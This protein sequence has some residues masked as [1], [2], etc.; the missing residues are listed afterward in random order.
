MSEMG[1][2]GSGYDW[3]SAESEE[4]IETSAEVLMDIHKLATN[5]ESEMWKTDI[6]TIDVAS[7]QM[8]FSDSLRNIDMDYEEIPKMVSFED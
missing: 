5:Q 8:K 2:F 4:E 3:E 1:L 6:P 7:L